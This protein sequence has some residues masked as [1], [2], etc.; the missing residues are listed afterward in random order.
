MTKAVYPGTFDPV[1]R[2]HLDIAERAS[3]IF[4]GLVLAVAERSTK[5]LTFSASER[6]ELARRSIEEAGLGGDVTVESFDGLLVDYM[7]TSG[8]SVFVR[9]LRANSDFEYEF[10]M[11]LI[12]RKMAP[13]ITGIYLMPAEHNMYLSSTVVK[14]IAAFRGDLRGFVTPAVEAA[15]LARLGGEG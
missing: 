11:Q 4:G 1:T 6:I 10:Q 3:E 12:N 2:G 13:W 15:L 9:G 5:R 8:A 14:E 7:K